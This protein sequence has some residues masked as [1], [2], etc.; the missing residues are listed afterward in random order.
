MNA[1]LETTSP[2]P[3]RSACQPLFARP[4]RSRFL[5][6][7]FW[8]AV[9]WVSGGLIAGGAVELFFRH[10]ESVI[11]IRALQQEMAKGAAFKIQ[12]YVESIAHTLRAASRTPGIVA[13]GF[14]DRYRFHLRRLF[15]VLPALTSITA[16]DA[17]GRAQLTESRVAL[18]IPHQLSSYAADA[19]FAR[20]KSGAAFFGQVY[21]VRRSE[22]YMRVAVPIELYAGKVI[23]VLIAEVNLKYIWEVISRIKVGK[24]GYAYV[25]SSEGDLIAHPDISLAL[26]KQNLRALTH[27]QQALK[28]LPS[29]DTQMNLQGE[30]VFT[31]HAAIPTLGWIVFV[32]RLRSEAYAPLRASLLRLSVLLLLGLGLAALASGLI[33]RRFLR[34]VETLRQGAQALGEEGLH[35][36]IALRTGDEFEA[37]ADAFNRMAEQLQTS[38]AELELKVQA[39]TEE[40][41]HSVAEL[42]I[43][44]QHKSRFLAHMSHELRT[45]LHAVMSFIQFTLDN[46]YGDIPERARQRLQRAHQSSAHLLRLIETLLD[47]AKI[48]AG[49]FELE[50]TPYAMRSLVETVAGA[51]E[52]QAKAKGLRLTVQLAADLPI[53][54]GDE[55]RL[56]Q[57]LFNLVSNAI[58]YTDAGDIVIGVEASAGDFTLTVSDTGRGMTPADLQRVFEPFEQAHASADRVRSGAGLGL[59]ICKSIIELHQGAI[60]VES[61][62]GEGSVF[63]CVFPVRVA[64]PGEPS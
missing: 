29:P 37:L 31:T 54:L 25:V 7:T 32:E 50:V 56:T 19:A 45:P 63:W 64:S 17:E 30:S 5:R 13:E 58:A 4:R 55:G 62:P 36:R 47:I 21:F 40:L 8:I 46:Q 20:A 42:E 60:G 57:V 52:N 9:F 24:S 33:R 27:V 34:P 26:R 1:R 61:S 10:H 39:R 59:S 38:Y 53:G 23:G 28:G 41:A 2:T 18:A 43:A 3:W 48:E 22:P 15:R 12:Q 14:T 6:R 35:H 51:L 11:G 16:A 44:S 49:H